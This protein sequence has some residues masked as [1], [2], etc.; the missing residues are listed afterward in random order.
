MSNPNAGP[1]GPGGT[2]GPIPGS[3]FGPGQRPSPEQ[4]QMMQRQIAAEAEKA[5]MSVPEF[6]EHV[7]KQQIARMQQQRAAGGAGAGTGPAGP[8]GLLQ[9]RRAHAGGLVKQGEM[10]FGGSVIG[11]EGGDEG[12]ASA[13]AANVVVGDWRPGSMVLRGIPGIARRQDGTGKEAFLW[14]ERL[15]Q[16]DQ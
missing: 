7:K 4:I 1:G 6:V 16:E 2:G 11:L 5:G 8:A 10:L 9:G 14:L 3:P 15:Q 12:L 13:R